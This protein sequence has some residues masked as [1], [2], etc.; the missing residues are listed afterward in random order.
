[1]PY[2]DIN[3]KRTAK[4]L[5]EGAR[6]LESL[7]ETGD[8]TEAARDQR[9]SKALLDTAGYSVASVARVLNGIAHDIERESDNA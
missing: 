3:M 5:R 4:R 6:L 7:L 2:T 1:M 8:A 9:I